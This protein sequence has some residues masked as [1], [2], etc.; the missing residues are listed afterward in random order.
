[1]RWLSLTHD[2][3]GRRG[4]SKGF[5]LL[6]GWAPAFP[7]TS[8][9]IIGTFLSYSEQQG[10]PEFLGRACE[11]GDWEIEVQNPDGGVIVGLFSGKPKPSTVFN[12]GMVIHGW[13]DLDERSIDGRYLEAAMRAG[14]FLVSHQDTDGAWRGHVEYFR[15]PHTYN[16][17]VA[18]ALLRLA[19]ATGETRFGVSARRHLDWVLTMQ[20]ENGWFESCCFK[21]NSDPNTHA[22][23]YT[24]RGLLESYVLTDREPYLAAVLRTSE[25]L[26]RKLETLGRLPASF[27]RLWRPVSSYE[28]LTGTVQLGGVWLRL[29]QVTRDARFLN[30]GLKAVEQAAVRQS[31]QAWAPLRGALPGSYP[32]YGRY[33]PLLYPNWATKFL[34]D[35]L[36]LRQNLVVAEHL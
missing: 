1:M 19:A 6:S 20:K 15:I 8:G 25:V 30:A 2:V 28:S 31:R 16:S 33:A 29:Y 34:V 21:P 4:S 13:I 5:S 26:I 35:S 14:M 32:I 3:T 12:T 36:M 18:W 9:Y 11:L 24:L 23:A 7:E 27:D 10:S 17:R 22:L